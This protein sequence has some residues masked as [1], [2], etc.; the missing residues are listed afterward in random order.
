MN[1][2]DNEKMLRQQER[3]YGGAFS[4]IQQETLRRQ[5]LL[6]GGAISRIQQEISRRQELLYGSAIS[7]LQQETLR[8]QELLY[9]SVFSRMQEM[10][11]RSD[12]LNRLSGG[13][14]FSALRALDTMVESSARSFARPDWDVLGTSLGAFA[15]INRL[16]EAQTSWMQS[17]TEQIKHT[18]FQALAK[19]VLPATDFSALAPSMELALG[20][21]ALEFPDT[22]GTIGN[23]FEAVARE[24]AEG[25]NEAAGD[26]TADHRSIH[27][28]LTDLLGHYG[29]MDAE[30]RSKVLLAV[31]VLMI[32]LAGGAIGESLGGEWNRFR[33]ASGQAESL[34]V[35]NAQTAEMVRIQGDVGRLLELAENPPRYARVTRRA[36]LRNGPGAKADKVGPILEVG[37]DLVVLERKDGWLRVEAEPTPGDVHNG[38]VYGRLTRYID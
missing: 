11:D 23:H 22:F 33:E 26:N 19:S 3:L 16:V 30:G 21:A 8:H 37:T 31:A 10:L 1:A 38:W 2:H 36:W 7:R 9:G 24:I 35:E 13:T 34:A 14:V 6:Y 25:I 4:R 29:L 27:D 15:P 12:L 5:E 17:L 28:F 32:S 18:P 20:S